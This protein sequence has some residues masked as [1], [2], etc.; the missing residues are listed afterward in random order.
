MI[1]RRRFFGRAACGAVGAA[2]ALAGTGGARASSGHA[3][4]SLD[5]EQALALLKEGNARFV[6]DK[7]V[8]EHEGRARRAEIAGGQTPFSGLV[9]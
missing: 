3:G 8:C 5:A 7:A 1:D 6:A 4:T 9:L 2:A